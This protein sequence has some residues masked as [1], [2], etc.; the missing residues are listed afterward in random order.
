MTVQAV[1]SDNLNPSQPNLSN[2]F[3][4]AT[5][6]FINLPLDSVE[7]S[8]DCFLQIYIPTNSGELARNLPLGKIEQQTFFLNLIDTES[9]LPIPVELQSTGLE[10]A[11]LFL[12]SDNTYLEAFIVK[13]DYDLPSSLS[14]IDNKLNLIL[15]E[16]NISGQNNPTI[17]EQQFFFIN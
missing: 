12:A 7:L 15:N 16:L 3:V 8:I 5:A 14:E 11:L 10:M 6:F 17:A 1:F 13:Q 4:D 9:I 2:R